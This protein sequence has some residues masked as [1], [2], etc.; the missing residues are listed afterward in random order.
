MV[1]I[2][3][4]TQIVLNVEFYRRNCT[5]RGGNKQYKSSNSRLWTHHLFGEDEAGNVG[6]VEEEV[7][8]DVRG[9]GVRHL[10][11]GAEPLVAAAVHHGVDPGVGQPVLRGA[12]L[13]AQRAAQVVVAAA[14]VRPRVPAHR[15]G[16]VHPPAL[17]APVRAGHADGVVEV[18]LLEV[19]A[20]AAVAEDGAAAVC[21]LEA[22]VVLRRE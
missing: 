19:G 12:G 9:L 17:A 2:V 21:G 8:H 20:L 16:V 5:K 4:R 3:T 13:D 14:P 6:D 18:V 10:E 7:A 11:A 22:G 1:M 15:E